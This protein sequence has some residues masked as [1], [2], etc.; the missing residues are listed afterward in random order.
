MLGGLLL[1]LIVI[2]FSASLLRRPLPD[3]GPI[4]GNPGVTAVP[5]TTPA[6]SAA[7]VFQREIVPLIEV[8]DRKNRQA[9]DRA[10]VT[11][12]D[13]FQ[14]LHR[15]IPAFA[16][17]I[18]GWGTRFGVVGRMSSDLWQ[19][20]WHENQNANGVQVYVSSKFQSHVISDEKLKV[21]VEGT[22]TQFQEDLAANRNELLSQVR[23]VLHREDIPVR[24]QFDENSFRKFAEDVMRRANALTVSMGQRS[25]ASF[26]LTETAS[27]VVGAIATR[28]AIT[29]GTYLATT[30]GAAGGA[31]VGGTAVGGGAGTV[32][33]P[34]VGT[35][36][37]AGIGLIVG[38]IIDWW[39]T[40]DFK[41][42]ISGECSRF[43]NEL[44]HFVIQGPK[45]GVQFQGSDQWK[46]LR[47]VFEDS[48]TLADK[49]MRQAMLQSLVEK[50]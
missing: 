11:L 14:Q 24:L 8:Y 13:R 18:T 16:D 39:M 42:K 43:L 48:I 15:G 27:G 19:K 6:E 45:E 25:L 26:I 33:T 50:Q 35:V 2:V 31:T 23:T 36:I 10:I 44:E 4:S 46:G 12:K 47:L 37:G 49:S 7:A 3:P 20:W 28:L 40:E 1:G 32:V 22:V 5:A 17:D 30:L 21:A 34:G 38:A 41:V 29:G 9:A